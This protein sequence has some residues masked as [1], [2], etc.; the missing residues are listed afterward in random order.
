[1]GVQSIA[2]EA[3]YKVFLLTLSPS[4]LAFMLFCYSYHLTPL[5]GF[6]PTFVRYI[7]GWG[8]PDKQQQTFDMLSC[9]GGA[10]HVMSQSGILGS[11]MLHPEAHTSN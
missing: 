5:L 4:S 1:M 9:I 3:R 2:N 7:W 11:S 8:R 10:D 6:S